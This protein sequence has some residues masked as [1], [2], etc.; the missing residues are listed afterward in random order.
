MKARGSRRRPGHP[1]FAL[2]A[3]LAR[4]GI[5]RDAVKNLAEPRR[6]ERLISEALRP[7]SSAEAWAKL[8]ADRQFG[9]H[10]DAALQNISVIEAAQ[11][12]GGIACC[13]G[14]AA[15]SRQ[16]REKRRRWSRPTAR[17]RGACSPRSRAGNIA[18]EDSGG[19]RW[20]ARRPGFFARLAA[21]VALGGLAPVTL[22]ALLKHPLSRLGADSRAVA[23]LER[24]VLRGPRPRP[25]SKGLGACAATFRD[26]LAKFRRKE[27][28]GSAS[29]R[30]AHYA[31]RKRTGGGRRSRGALGAA[32]APLE[33]IAGQSLSA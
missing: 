28:F 5:A 25:G 8:A 16:R 18:A 6:R 20:P 29:L 1:Q 14:C 21:E 3:L 10:A 26:E 30:S 15:R 32:L 4:I 33:D 11:R 13:R 17:L 31:R 2:Q 19:E 27:S 22:L 9:A 23:A 12:R 7:A 24:A